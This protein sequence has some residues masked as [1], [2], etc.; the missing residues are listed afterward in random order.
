MKRSLILDCCLF[1]RCFVPGRMRRQA[2]AFE[3][4]NVKPSDPSVIKMGKGRALPGGR[5]E[6]P[7]YTVRELIMFTY[8]VTDDMISGGPKWVGE[9]RFDIVAK[10][11]AG[12]LRTIRCAR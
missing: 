2:P 10:A 9:D 6:V 11:P 7:G 5:L 1:L 3:V 12:A 4:A 8:G